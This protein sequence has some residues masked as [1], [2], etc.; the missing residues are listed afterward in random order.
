MHTIKIIKVWRQPAADENSKPQVHVKCLVDDK[1]IGWDNYDEDIVPNKQTLL[2]LVEQNADRM[3]EKAPKTVEPEELPDFYD[4]DID[5]K[6]LD[7][8]VLKGILKV[9]VNEINIL[10]AKAGLSKRTEEQVRNAI[11]NIVKG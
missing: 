7:F 3:L 2:T 10:R 9:M 6:K 1:V 5:T 4:W 11:K 8:K